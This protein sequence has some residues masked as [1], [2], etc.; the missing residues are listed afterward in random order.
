MGIIIIQQHYTKL[1]SYFLDILTKVAYLQKTLI[2]CG[3]VKNV[4]ACCT[5]KIDCILQVFVH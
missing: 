3:I 5:W 4:W 2:H 1:I